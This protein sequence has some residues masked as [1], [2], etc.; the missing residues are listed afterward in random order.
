MNEIEKYAAQWNVS[1]KFFYDNKYFQW[2]CDKLIGFAVVLEIGCGTGYSTLE[3]L[4][5]GHRVIA[6]EKNHE[7][8]VAAEKL[9]AENGFTENH[10][11]FLEGDIVDLD[12]LQEIISKYDFNI[13]ICWNIGTYWNDQMQEFY[14]PF[15][16]DY[17]LTIGQILEDLESS[18]AELIIWNACKIA[19]SKNVPT[20]IVERGEKIINEESDPH[21]YTLKNEFRFNSIVYDN[22]RAVSVS[23]G[24]RELKTKRGAN[25]TGL[26]DIIFI[27]ILMI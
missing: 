14:I 9:V 15:M 6:I 27:S 11:I 8:I 1:A 21:Y 4:I 12:F 18:Y 3:L 22:Y 23:A 24:G 16:K 19:S 17:G 26:V 2:M 5:R 25:N 10:V 20:H 13:V 7:C